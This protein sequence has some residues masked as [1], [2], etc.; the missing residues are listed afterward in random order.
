MEVEKRF[1]YFLSSIIL[2]F[3]TFQQVCSS[4]QCLKKEKEKREKLPY[5]KWQKLSWV[6][7][8][9]LGPDL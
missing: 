2:N 5:L 3:L 9:T 8:Q 4:E 7:S 1:Y 6:R